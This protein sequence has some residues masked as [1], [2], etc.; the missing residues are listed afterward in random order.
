MG[1]KRGFWNNFVICD[2]GL[3]FYMRE[4]ILL[5]FFSKGYEILVAV[6]ML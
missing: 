6:T 2:F 4:K 1:E 5:I 3:F